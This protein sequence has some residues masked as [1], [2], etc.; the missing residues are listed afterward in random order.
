[1][2]NE[3]KKLFAD[4]KLCGLNNKDSALY[5]GYGEKSAASK[6]CQLAKNEEIRTHIAA[7]EHL[8]SL[9]KLEKPQIR[10]GDVH[11][12]AQ[13]EAQ[14][15]RDTRVTS[16]PKESAGLTGRHDITAARVAE[17]FERRR[18]EEKDYVALI[19]DESPFQT[20]EEFLRFTMNNPLVP[21]KDRVAAAK[22]LQSQ[23]N[24]TVK[25]TGKK[26]LR[27]NDAAEAGKGRFGGM[28]PPPRMVVNNK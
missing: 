13:E 14:R 2:L 23:E 20:P 5:A 15:K 28:S 26:E 22:A 25:G 19:L 7:M 17:T 24:A 12:E 8:I 6:G 9:G 10:P 27:K 16:N 1:M 18:Q 21:I 11:G 4:A 3:Q